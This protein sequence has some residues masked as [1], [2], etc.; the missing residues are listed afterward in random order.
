MKEILGHQLTE[1]II[2]VV[3]IMALIAAAKMLFN[4]LPDGGIPGD[5]KKFFMLA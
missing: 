5:V 3:V 4:L 2:N 1:L